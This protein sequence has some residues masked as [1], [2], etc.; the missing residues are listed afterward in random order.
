M[1]N[2]I[3]LAVFLFAF[4]VSGW[5]SDTHGHEEDGH[6]EDDHHEQG[7]HDDGH[8]GEGV[9]ELS[10]A[11]L[12]HA[13][14]VIA[15]GAAREIEET[16]TLHGKLQPE[17]TAISHIRARY[18][19]LVSQIDVSIGDPVKKGQRLASINSNESLQEYTLRAPFDGVVIEKHA[20]PGEFVSEQVLFTVADYRRLWADLQVFPERLAS[21][22]RGQPVE[23]TAGELSYL[24]EVR[25][26]VPAAHG[27]P[28][29]RARVPVDN[30]K[31]D[32]SSGIF[33]QGRVTIA[34]HA[35]AIAIDNRALQ[36]LE[37]DT[38]VFVETAPNRFEPRPVHLGRRGN[39]FSEV[40]GGLE[41]GERY[42]AENS[43]LIKAE[44][45]KSAAGHVH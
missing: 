2:K 20:G 1:F 3:Y 10:D 5:G 44:L 22:R 35:V 12:A 29:R 15:A 13:G 8:H 25:N 24:G 31:G 32:W 21:V 4:C 43:Y 6:H 34:T 36:T 39:R 28:Y 40:L 14:V 41:V 33:V 7:H 9:V 19:G 11:A 27:A 16:V 42:V 17:P 18:P 38:V 37:G 30:S 23:I 26:L 45:K